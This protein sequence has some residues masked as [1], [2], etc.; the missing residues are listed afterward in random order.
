LLEH[1]SVPHISTEICSGIILKTIP[2]L[3]KRQ[4]ITNKGQLVP[5]PVTI[6]MVKDRL[7]QP[8]V[9]GGFL[10]DGFPAAFRRRR[11]LKKFLLI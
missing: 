4:R 8:D 11:S 1:L 2:N 9:K 7:S 10:L 3:E 5:I 6:A